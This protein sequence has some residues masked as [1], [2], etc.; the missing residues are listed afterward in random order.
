MAPVTCGNDTSCSDHLIVPLFCDFPN[1]NDILSHICYDIFFY[2]LVEIQASLLTECFVVSNFI[3]MVV[4]VTDFSLPLNVGSATARS[5]AVSASLFD[6]MIWC[7]FSV[8]LFSER[9]STRMVEPYRG[10]P[11]EI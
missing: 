1:S 5:L 9:L 6:I 8:L 3:G 2:G 4:E 11:R 10:R 7:L